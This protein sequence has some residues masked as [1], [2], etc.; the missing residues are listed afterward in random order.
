MPVEP[1]ILRP[2]GQFG[3]QTLP[4][5]E[6]LKTLI[7]T[8]NNRKYIDTLRW[9]WF[10]KS[11]AIAQDKI[12][13]RLFLISK[14]YIELDDR[15]SMYDY[16]SIEEEEVVIEVAGVS[17]DLSSKT[18][19]I[20]YGPKELER[21]VFLYGVPAPQLQVTLDEDPV[22]EAAMTT[23]SVKGDGLTFDTLSS[24]GPIS[25][26][27]FTL[28]VTSDSEGT[29]IEQR[30]AVVTDVG[31]VTTTGARE[32]DQSTFGDELLERAR[33]AGITSTTTTITGGY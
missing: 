15:S 17:Q 14:E 16:T 31:G 30:E 21:M 10:P 32:N 28:S 18:F 19:S 2:P 4:Q 13:D 9:E 8:P 7:K 20:S 3:F 26:E 5:I 1:I 11:S 29:A 23:N 25:Q 27:G 33:E 24:L 12:L 22:D 6:I